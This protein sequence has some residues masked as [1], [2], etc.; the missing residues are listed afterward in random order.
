MA[1]VDETR[2]VETQEEISQRVSNFGYAQLIG[3]QVEQAQDGKGRARIQIDRR[4]MHPQQIVH[5]GVIFTLADSAMSMALIST[6]P[7]GTPFSTIEAKINYLAP[8]RSGDIVAEATILQQG[9]TIAVLEANIYNIE[10]EK[11]RLIGRVLG[12]F[13]ISTSRVI[14]YKATNGATPA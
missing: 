9:R 7:A 12:T 10:Q 5:G 14:D 2:P 3:M 11:Q 13:H 8:A 1:S 6:L 4:L